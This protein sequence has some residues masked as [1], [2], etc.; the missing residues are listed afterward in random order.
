MNATIQPAQWRL[1]IA[2]KPLDEHSLRKLVEM[3]AADFANYAD[4]KEHG[5]EYAPLWTSADVFD[6]R[7]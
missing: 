2:N 4:A 7:N 6:S 1:I 5:K 3:I